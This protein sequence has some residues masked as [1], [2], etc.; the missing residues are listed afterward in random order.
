MKE[1]SNNSSVV[2]GL[3]QMSMQEDEASNLSKA[4]EMIEGAAKFGAEIVC[5]PELFASRYFP[6]EKDAKNDAQTIPGPIT[7]SLSRC[8]RKNSVCLVGGSIF[9]KE[10]DKT[11]NTSVVFDNKGKILGKYR[12][13]HIP[14]DESFYEQNYFVSGKE[15]K[16]FNTSKA[17][18]G[19]LICFDQW[20][21]EPARALRLL[22]SQIVFYPTAIGNVKG[23]EQ[24]EGD[25]KESWI[26][27]QRGH[28]ISNGMIISAVN[29]VGAEGRMKFWG[30]SFV[31]DEFGKILAKA[32]GKEEILVVKCDLNLGEEVEEGWGFL[33]NRKPA[34]YGNLIR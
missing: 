2:L 13:V 17:K 22:G 4:I 25:W 8:A 9:E 30:S 33:R 19:V 10:H 31:C 26:A 1:M 3:A 28:A 34:T 23:I 21:P 11:Y 32:G 27:V 12:K 15:Y 29:R 5:L 24:M 18:I 6:Q 7:E 16:V 14:Q 20:Y